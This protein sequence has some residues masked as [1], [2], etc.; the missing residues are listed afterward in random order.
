M[1]F[2]ACKATIK[3]DS[4]SSFAKVAG[5]IFQWMKFGLFTG[6][7]FAPTPPHDHAASGHL[8]PFFHSQA[9]KGI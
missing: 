1:T 7:H 2:M 8:R 9:E 6:G 4:Q 5:D 3:P